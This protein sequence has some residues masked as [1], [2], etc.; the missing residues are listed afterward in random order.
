MDLPEE[1]VGHA[2]DAQRVHFL[3]LQGLKRLSGK[4]EEKAS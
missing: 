4:G 2:E 3:L 1:K